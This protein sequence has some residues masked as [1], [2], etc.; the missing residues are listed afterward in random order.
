MNSSA[1]TTPI[2]VLAL[3]GAAVMLWSAF[4]GQ[5]PI[6]EL[7]AT[8][9]TGRLPG[10]TA[11]PIRPGTLDGSIA[12]VA[13]D[14]NPQ[15]G[16]SSGGAYGPFQPGSTGGPPTLVPLGQGSHRLQPA[17]VA[18][19]RTVEQRFGRSIPITDSARDYSAQA[20]GHANDPTRF[21]APQDNAHVMGLAVDVDLAAV[22]ANPSGSNPADWQIDPVYRSLFAAFTGAGWCNWQSNRGDL[23][24][25]IPE[26]WHFSFGRCG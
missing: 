6:E 26:P 3:G 7:R 17:A 23:G 22:G 1:V 9:S 14:L 18:A 15:G 12:P 4:T 13:V 24:G 20:R 21:G 16:T 25:K 2:G 8:L 10:R 11:T 5:N 19:F